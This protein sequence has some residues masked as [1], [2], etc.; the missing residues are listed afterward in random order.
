MKPKNPQKIVVAAPP[1]GKTPPSFSVKRSPLVSRRRLTQ[2][3][4]PT[5]IKQSPP[6]AGTTDTFSFHPSLTEGYDSSA[7]NSTKQGSTGSSFGSSSISPRPSPVAAKPRCLNLVTNSEQGAGG[8][9]GVIRE[10]AHVGDG[11]FDGDNASMMSTISSIRA[12]FLAEKFSSSNVDQDFAWALKMGEEK[13]EREVNFKGESPNKHTR[14]TV[15]QAGK[16]PLHDSPPKQGQLPHSLPEWA[17]PKMTDDDELVGSAS[18]ANVANDQLAETLAQVRDHNYQQECSDAINELRR[19][20]RSVSL[21]ARRSGPKATFN[22]EVAVAAA[23]AVAAAA[24]AAMAAAPAAEA[25]RSN[26]G[27]SAPTP[28]MTRSASSSG[29]AIRGPPLPQ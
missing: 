10:R 26:Q 12:E 5:D 3:K 9:M 11:S 19:D 18:I 17:P 2:Q 29:G 23:E 28:T 1:E 21:P 24:E 25:A 16:P 22:D 6:L 14:K 15:P 13:R 8:G 4:S 20:H 27:T 7:S